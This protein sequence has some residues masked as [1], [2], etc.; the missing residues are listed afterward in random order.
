MTRTKSR[1][2]TLT[3]AA[4]LLALSLA[5]GAAYAQEKDFDIE[6][7]PLAKALLDFNEQSG[8]TV[9][10]PRDLVADK[11]SSAVQGEME[12]EEALEKILAG[13]G[14]K[15]TELPTG[16]YTI[17]LA[18]ASLDEGSTEARPFRV[19][20]VDQG[21]GVRA[22]TPQRDDEDSE[23]RQDVIV[24]TGTNVRG[25]PNPTS[26]VFVYDQE[27][28]RL[29]GAATAQDFIRTLPQNLDSSE[30]SAGGLAGPDS[31]LG[32]GAAG[33]NIRGLGTTATLT[34]VNGRRLAAGAGSG[35][36]VDISLFPLSAI[37]RVEVLTDGAS[38]IYGADAV[39][40][41]VNFILRD[42]YDGA[43]TQV[44]VGTA[45]TGRG[46]PKEF[47]ASQTFGRAWSTGNAM[48]SYEYY[49]RNNL[50][51][52]DRSFTE[53]ADDPTDLVP[54]Q[55]RQSILLNARQELNERLELFGTLNFSTKDSALNRSGGVVGGN[56]G[57]DA[58]D[59]QYGGNISAQYDFENDWRVKLSGGYNRNE[60]DF[61]RRLDGS[62][63]RGID[64]RF[65]LLSAD[66]IADGVWFQLPGGPVRVAVG[67]HFRS[68]NFERALETAT[69]SD[70]IDLDR[71]VF[72]AF[73]EVVLPVVGE[74]NRRP[75]IYALDI[76]AAGR[77]EDFSDAGSSTN[78][79]IGL[80]YAPI[81][82]LSFRGTYSTAFQAPR[83]FDIGTEQFISALPGFFFPPAPGATDPTPAV[84]LFTGGNRELEPETSENYSFG[85]DYTPAFSENTKLSLTYFDI[86]FEDRVGRPGPSPFAVF[87]TP[88]AFGDSLT[89]NPDPSFVSDLFAD[90]AFSNRFG[91]QATDVGAIADL[92]LQNLAST[93]V[94]GID[95]SITHQEETSIGTLSLDFNGSYLFDFVDQT[96]A[97]SDPVETLSTVGK[98]VDFRFRSNV[99]W[100]QDGY[101]ANLYV[102]YVNDYESTET[103]V[104]VPVASW[105]TVDL[106]LSYD[107]GTGSNNALLKNTQVSLNARNLFNEDPPFV[108]LNLGTGINFDGVNANAFGRQISVA[109][110]KAW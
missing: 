60:T 19:A 108:D 94:S 70:T 99:G 30:A 10:A 107:F 32:G 15:S 14:L 38:A 46:S 80:R 50:D 63:E 61:I 5:T 6:A 91:V 69:T 82:G 43:E 105:T 44:R 68:E 22:V 79:K 81:E 83:L 84:L 95:F 65:D 8:L 75:G 42:D 36:F 104:T 71:E 26:P 57:Q 40:G 25:G 54:N 86:D 66:L 56:E 45:T 48:V 109:L 2:F 7:Q 18:S 34:L 29:S 72:A 31:G 21:D 102:N 52:N 17:T 23:A 24:V 58:T 106:N 92:R 16:A 55:E 4:S 73:A 59:E 77:F 3:G 27:A 1:K 12:P 88:E 33:V 98:P 49:R 76:T 85:I 9:A 89:I 96:S 39:A 67:S 103:G 97:A 41:V 64:T 53:G 11:L 100:R 110:T 78:P 28:I 13:S 74:D 101:G 93:E 47:Q 87:T 51:A 37:E 35:E 20:Q 90:P 62:F